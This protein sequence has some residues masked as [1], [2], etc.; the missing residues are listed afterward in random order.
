MY[1]LSHVFWRENKTFS[2]FLIAV[3]CANSS[4]AVIGL[5]RLTMRMKDSLFT[6][7]SFQ[8]PD[9]FIHIQNAN[10]DMLDNSEST[11]PLR[12]E[13]SSLY[14]LM[15]G[16]FGKRSELHYLH[17]CIKHVLHQLQVNGCLLHEYGNQRAV[18]S[19]DLL[20]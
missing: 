5:T 10:E 3:F 15:I 12:N 17:E 13:S 20:K 2:I 4:S 1:A 6:L 9:I 7:R 11:I 16:M 18:P 8:T 14:Y 19:A